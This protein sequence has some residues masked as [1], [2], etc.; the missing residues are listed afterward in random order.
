MLKAKFEV[1]EWS[2]HYDETGE[3]EERHEKTKYFGYGC[4]QQA[5]DYYKE[6]MDALMQEHV[7]DEAFKE[8]DPQLPEYCDHYCDFSI[9]EDDWAGVR[10]IVRVTNEK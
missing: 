5:C 10:L 6:R 9:G 3:C 2:T 4:Y 8:R 7:P 1:M